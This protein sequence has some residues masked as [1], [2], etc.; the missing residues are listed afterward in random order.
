[1]DRSTNSQAVPVESSA[2]GERRL[3]VT[4]G[5]VAALLGSQMGNSIVEAI[6]DL[7][8]HTLLPAFHVLHISGLPFCN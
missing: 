2:K 4:A 7:W 5:I 1:M 6:V 8:L 3:L